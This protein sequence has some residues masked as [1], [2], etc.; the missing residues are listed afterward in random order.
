MIAYDW[1][2]LVHEQILAILVRFYMKVKY[3]LCDLKP[4]SNPRLLR[5]KL[6]FYNSFNSGE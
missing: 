5:G 4:T 1:K 6:I 2:L 3:E